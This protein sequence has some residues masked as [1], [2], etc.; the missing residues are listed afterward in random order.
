MP[1]KP[2]WHGDGIF[3]KVRARDGKTVYYAQYWHLG[4]RITEKGGATLLQA[5]KLRLRRLDEIDN[6]TFVHP[7]EKKAEA[8][9]A[10]LAKAGE[11]DLIFETA[12][13]R[14]IDRCGSD[15][16]DQKAVE[17]CFRRLGKVFDGRNLAEVRRA[18]VMQYQHDRLKKRGAFRNWTRKVGPR[19]PQLELTALSALYSYLIADEG[20]D[21]L[22]PC[23]SPAARGRKKSKAAIYRPEHKP[24][25]ADRAAR[26]ALFRA[27]SDDP[28]MRAFLKLTYYTATRPES[29]AGALLHG[30]VELPDAGKVRAIRGKLAVWGRVTFRDTKNANDRQV[31]LHPRA[32]RSLRRIMLPRP[33]DSSALE[34]W[35]ALPV[36][37]RR[38]EGAWD[39]SS[40]RDRWSKIR[41]RASKK[42][43]ELAS[44]WV[45]D[46]RK[47]ANTE[48]R[49]G[50]TDTATAARILGHSAEMNYRYVEAT[51]EAAQRALAFL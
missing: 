12:W 45:R 30:D 13:K 17:G 40:Y 31:L 37:R 26:L 15:Y 41:A 3:S 39:V 2:Q 43:P 16:A 23:H 25:I 27:C 20:R 34:R 33:N 4:K 10:V 6:R 14:F 47:T 48:M 44:M 51:D 35:K 50:G 11:K 29:E 8:R 5:Q 9:A 38:T 46:L 22:N 42:H 32:A 49:Q 28:E 19:V 7:G 1:E 21:I 36:F 18:D 24:V